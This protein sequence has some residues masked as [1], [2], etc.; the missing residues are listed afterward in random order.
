M[1]TPDKFPSQPETNPSPL[2]GPLTFINLGSNARMQ[3]FLKLVQAASADGSISPEE[4]AVLQRIAVEMGMDLTE[5][6]H[7]VETPTLVLP[8]PPEAEHQR[9]H[10]LEQMVEIM[11][12]DGNL[13]EQEVRYCRAAA[14]TLGF[15]PGRVEVMTKWQIRKAFG[16]KVLAENEQT[17]TSLFE[18]VELME[19]A[20]S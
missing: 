3:R 14:R 11:L 20:F 2:A 7:A 12:A 5:V 1:Q 13:H 6:T 10:L 19:S 17:I 18:R 15:R 9:E 4:V 8:L 16:D